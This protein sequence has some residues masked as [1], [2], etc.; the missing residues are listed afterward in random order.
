MPITYTNRR[1]VTFYLCQSTT[2]TGKPR[3]Y[4]AREP[5]GSPVEQVPEGFRISESANGLVSLA[6]DRP[7]Q[8]LPAEV[9]A[10]DAAIARHPKPHDY[11]VGVKRD[12]IEISERLGPNVDELA[13]ALGGSL[14]LLPGALDRLRSELA[15]Q[16]RFAPALRFCLIDAERRTFAVERWCSLGSIDD[17]I[18][19]GLSGPLD[20]LVEPA[21]ARLGDDSFYDPFWD[22]Y[23]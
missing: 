16:G 6:R 19:V 11:H 22:E 3:Y 12:R 20:R 15:T 21:V 10:V 18:D 23:D 17:W 1:G 13:R 7:S 14:G 8:I 5:R 2:K 4:F 9:A